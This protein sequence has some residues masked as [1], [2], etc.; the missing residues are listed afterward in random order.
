[1]RPLEKSPE[2][3]KASNGPF[4]SLLNLSSDNQTLYF[5]D[6]FGCN[7]GVKISDEQYQALSKKKADYLKEHRKNLPYE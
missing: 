6:N 4:Q 7:E 3:L 1:M 2:C 5:S